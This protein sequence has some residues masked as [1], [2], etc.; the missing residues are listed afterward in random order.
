MTC[1]F[2]FYFLLLIVTIH[3]AS[4][5]KHITLSTAELNNLN[6]CW[7]GTLNYSG[8]MIRKP[9]TTKARLT[10]KQ[11]GQA[12]AYSLVHAYPGN[13]LT[14]DTFNIS[15]NGSSVN[16]AHIL[17]KKT[18]QK[19]KLVIVTRET[20]D[21]RDYTQP[22]LIQKTYSIC[23]NKYTYTKKIKAKDQVEWLDREVFIYERIPCDK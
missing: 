9:Y 18:I 1:K 5:Q 23:K 8:T 14:S 7:R 3:S 20:G 10:I 12:K 2:L 13:E 17:S 21:D 15:T 19:G 22:V 16:G 6:G 4:A 11:I